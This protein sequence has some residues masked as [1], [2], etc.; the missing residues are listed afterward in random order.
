MQF[1][2]GGC[3]F[4]K[5]KHVASNITDKNQVLTGGLYFLYAVHMSRNDSIAKDTTIMCVSDNL[6]K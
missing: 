2:D 4:Q 1:P 3:L 6:Y 5:P